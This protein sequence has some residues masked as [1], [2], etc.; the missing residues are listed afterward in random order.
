MTVN[1]LTLRDFIGGTP[2]D[3]SLLD[4]CLLQATAL[5]AKYVGDNVV[6]VSVLDRA[7][8]EVAADLYH[9]RNAPNGVVNAQFALADGGLGGQAVRVTRDPMK[10]AYPLLRP[11]VSPW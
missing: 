4:D 8:I 1:V 7:H 10:S 3:V 5:I 9:R 6:P 2:T 11:W